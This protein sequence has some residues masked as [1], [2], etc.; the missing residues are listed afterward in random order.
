MTLTLQP[1]A[2]TTIISCFNFV[3]PRNRGVIIG[4]VSLLFLMSE[5][6]AGL[7]QQINMRTSCVH[8]SS[9]LRSISQQEDR[10]TCC[11]PGG[12]YTEQLIFNLWSC[13]PPPTAIPLRSMFMF[14]TLRHD[15]SFRFTY[16]TRVCITFYTLVNPL[17]HPTARLTNRN[18]GE[19]SC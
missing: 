3:F 1:L 7:P 4:H 11:E 18:D 9:R 17:F 19:V 5:T 2:T 14:L 15:I 8:G 6:L 13:A 10:L 12:N 16:I